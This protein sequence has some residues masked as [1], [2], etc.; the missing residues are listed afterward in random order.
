M[1]TVT[2]M[3]ETVVSPVVIIDLMQLTILSFFKIFCGLD[4]TCC[5][6]KKYWDQNK[7]L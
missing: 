4:L 7:I 3:E 5:F 1:L 2:T 6:E